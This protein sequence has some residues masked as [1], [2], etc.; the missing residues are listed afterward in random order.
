MLTPYQQRINGATWVDVN[1]T[2]TQAL[3]PE[4]FSDEQSVIYCSFYNLMNCPVGA[5]GR[6]FQPEYGSQL[7][8]LLQQPMGG[9]TAQEIKMSLM[10]TFARWEPRFKLNYAKTQVI[11]VY[12]LPGYRIRLVGMFILTGVESSVEFEVRS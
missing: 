2:F 1:P 5:R 11:P 4:R 7:Q 10:Q 3:V 8:W 6:I 12:E 9:A